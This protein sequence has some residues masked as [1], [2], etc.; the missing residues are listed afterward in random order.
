MLFVKINGGLW[1][2]IAAS[3]VAEPAALHI[4][5]TVCLVVVF[6]QR[7]ARPAVEQPKTPAGDWEWHR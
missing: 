7:R 1:S 2:S 6:R 4:H 5:A 3:P